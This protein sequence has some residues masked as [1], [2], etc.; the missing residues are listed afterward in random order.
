[1]QTF[2]SDSIEVKNLKNNLTLCIVT[3]KSVNHL[4]QTIKQRDNKI[5][6]LNILDYKNEYIKQLLN[7]IG[8]FLRK[9]AF[10]L[11]ISVD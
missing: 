10:E 2:S 8:Q 6:E 1:M 11:C 4:K 5:K 3:N 9:T 7:P